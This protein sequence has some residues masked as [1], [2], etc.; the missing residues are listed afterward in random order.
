MIVVFILIGIIVLLMIAM[1][2]IALL[3]NRKYF[4]RRY[5]GNPNLKYFTV[6]DFHQLDAEPI[7]FPSDKGQILRGYIYKSKQISPKD[8]I[9]FS[10]GYGAGHLSYTTEINTL[11]QAGFA[12]LAYDGTGCVA[13]DG[14]Y[15]GGFDQGPIDLQF[16][17]KFAKEHPLLR[18]FGGCVLMGHS[19]GGF[20]VM[21]S[22]NDPWVFGA[23]AMCG[24][25][26][27]A[28]V[29]AQ[30]AAGQTKKGYANRYWRIFVPGLAFLNWIK[31]GKDGNKN[32][33]KSLLRTN[34]PVL[35]LYGEKD[36]TVF[37]PNN[38]ECIKRAV[39]HKKN[40]TF[41]SFKNK[42]H[43]VYL[44]EQAE[45]NMYEIF[46]AIAKTFLKDKERAIQMYSQID[47]HKITQED[48]AVMKKIVDFCKNV[49]QLSDS[50][51]NS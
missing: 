37:Y 11:A 40:I 50:S 48:P 36:Q 26:D 49:L 18:S 39:L 44:T 34:K 12:V 43:N 22:V 32:S 41:L 3:A 4:R 19:W 24:F 14:K 1:L 25:V 47:Y 16:A 38:G 7:S 15:F 13:S 51:C 33:I 42:G 8:L 21:N 29:M 20:S 9:I 30:T 46:G 2:L 31:Y 45:E 23:V 5:D 27:G 10:H 35:L 28:S 6:D 17:I